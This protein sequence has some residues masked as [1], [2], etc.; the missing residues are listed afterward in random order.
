MTV[1]LDVD[2]GYDDALMILTALQFFDVA[3]VTTVAGNQSLEKVT[4][5]AL[6]ILELA[7]RADVPVAAGMPASL[8]NRVFY[9]SGV[10]GESGLDGA[11]LPEPKISPISEH[12]VDFII[13]QAFR[14]EDLTVIAVGPLT[15]VAAALIREPAA[16][17]RIRRISMMGGST[18]GGNVTPAAE[19]NIHADPEAADVVFRSGIPI[20]MYGLNVTAQTYVTDAD[21]DRIGRIGGAPAA[22]VAK[23]LTH[24]LSRMARSVGVRRASLHDPCAAAGLVCP[25]LFEMRPMHVAV[26]LTGRLTRGMTVC[27]RRH[28]EGET[29]GSPRPQGE[30]P[31]AEVAVAV[32][33][34]GWL[35]LIMEALAAYAPQ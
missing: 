7:G 3:G 16:A 8:T 28:L 23:M 22:A 15:N 2:P 5:N 34:L 13:D 33:R 24:Y 18:T 32:D 29:A 20:Q 26:E 14:H 4:R 1:L 27:D 31:N 9:A 19:F 11:E 21:V 25:Q 17:G 12:A 30:A 6:Q 35:E 10:H